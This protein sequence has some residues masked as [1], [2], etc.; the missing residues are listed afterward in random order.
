MAKTAKTKADLTEATATAS[1]DGVQTYVVTETA[2]ARVAGRRVKDGDTI[3]LSEEE[4]RGELLALHIRPE[5]SSNP[6]S[7]DV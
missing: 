1:T 7:T 4:A 2:P 5:A 6:P 3:E